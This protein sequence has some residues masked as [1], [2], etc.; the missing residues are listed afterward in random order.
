MLRTAGPMKITFLLPSRSPVP[1]GAYRTVYELADH[2]VGG[3]D[4]VAVV[5]PRTVV[6]T[7]GIKGR[8]K[9]LLWVRRYRGRPAG[10]APWFEVDPRVR[11]LAVADL[12]V[13]ALPDA[14]ALVAVT[15]E[16]APA[17][18]AA[19]PQKGVGFYFVQEGVPRPV[20]TVEAVEAA[21]ALPL[22]K[23]VI[24]GWLEDKARARGEAATTSRAPIGVDLERWGVDVP[25][26]GR[27]PRVAA[28]L[29][30]IKGEADIVAALEAARLQVPELE[31]SCYGTAERPAALPAWVIYEQLPDRAALRRLYNSASIFLQ[32][33]REEG[34]GLPPN[35]AMACGCALVTY[36][37]G[38]SRE[39]ARD[40]ET[41][42]VVEPPGAEGPAAAIVEL[43][44][45]ETLRL[46][47]AEAGAAFVGGLS[48][49]R[50]TAAFRMALVGAVESSSAIAG[51]KG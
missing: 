30:P 31:A 7:P 25:V 1:I 46:A 37:T 28:M 17:V 10:L 12:A 23:I 21:W 13:P 15:W 35:E 8:L 33:S 27:P 9:D 34:W 20:A 39:Y 18:A 44:R 47:L 40:R 51:A 45:D 22:H 6:A 16:A 49:E 32:T 41:A 50:A 5:H 4:E 26:A 24:A 3:G 11:L 29:N 38:G 48:W 19:A 14:D 2:L 42:L 43:A 36:D